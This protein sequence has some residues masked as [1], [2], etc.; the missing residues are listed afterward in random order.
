M[1]ELQ[2]KIIETY[3]RLETDR[4]LFQDIIKNICEIQDSN[5]KDSTKNKKIKQEKT[6]MHLFQESLKAYFDLL[7]GM[8]IEF[9]QI[10]SDINRTKQSLHRASSFLKRLRRCSNR[11]NDISSGTTKREKK[12][13]KT[14]LDSLKEYVEK[15]LL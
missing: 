9:D 1:E 7:E 14:E 5:L 4:N 12:E 8:D 13:I 6:K 3:A 10:Q 15:H 11:I 2:I